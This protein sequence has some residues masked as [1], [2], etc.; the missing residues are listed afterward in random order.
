MSLLEGNVYD[1]IIMVIIY[2]V[3]TFSL[4]NNIKEKYKLDLL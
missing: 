2:F 3:L 1:F 4:I